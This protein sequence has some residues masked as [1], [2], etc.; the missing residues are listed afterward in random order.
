LNVQIPYETGSGTA[1]LGVNNNG[2]VAHFE[3]QVQPSAPGI[4]MTLDGASNLVPYASGQRGQVLLAFVTGEGA[5]AP[6]LITGK[7]TTTSDIT[8]M[9]APTLPA[10]I[11]V[12]GVPATINFIGIPTG[13]VGVTQINFT[14]PPTAA[15][16]K[17]PVIVTVGGVASAPVNLTVTQ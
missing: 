11:T 12:G 5:V 9:P 1:V 2:Q 3:F 13:L 8:K 16:G 15:L 7:P 10:T 14:I 4:F 17:Q 6:A